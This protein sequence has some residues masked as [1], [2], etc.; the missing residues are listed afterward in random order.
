LE[1]VLIHSDQD[2]SGIVRV[3]NEAHGTVAAEFGF[4]KETNPTNN[5][6]IDERTLKTQMGKGIVLYALKIKD[7]I[8]GCIAIEKS[9]KETGTFYIEKVSVIPGHRHAG[10]GQKLMEFASDQIKGN[11]GKWISIALIDSN[12]RLKKWYLGQGF[13]ETGIRDFPHLPFR[14]CFMKKEI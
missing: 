1:Y 5:A 13:E 4:T 12:S 14:V 8:I 2:L 6:F 11:G 7:E 3:L 10:Y 9:V